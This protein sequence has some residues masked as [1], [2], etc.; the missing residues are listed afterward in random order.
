MTTQEALRRSERYGIPDLDSRVL[1]AYALGEPVSYVDTYPQKKI[2]QNALRLFEESLRKRSAGTPV[3][4]MTGEK[5]FYGL[6]FAV[7]KGQ[8]VC[9]DTRCRHR[10]RQLYRKRSRHMQGEKTLHLRRIGHL[11]RCARNRPT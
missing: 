2:P 7:F 9:A 1:L 4:Y 5:E 11:S 3:A 8:A 10:L 6:S